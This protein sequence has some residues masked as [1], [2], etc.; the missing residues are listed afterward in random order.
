MDIRAFREKQNINSRPDPKGFS[1][2]AFLSGLGQKEIRF[3]NPFG[4]KQ[5]ERFFAEIGM[6]LSAGV[7]LQTILKLSI[8]GAKTGDRLFK[9]YETILDQ[10]KQGE[11]LAAAMRI[12]GQFN[13]FDCF[14]VL[15]GENTGNLTDVFNRL[16]RYYNK[17]VIQR[18]KVNSSLS[19]P[20]IVLL[21]TIGTIYFMLKFVVPMF[22]ETLVKFGGELPPLTLL[23]IKLSHND[24]NYLIIAA[25]S[26]LCLFLLYKRN[27]HNNR[28]RLLLS[29]LVLSIPYVGNLVYKTH[30]VQ[31]T[32]AMDLLLSSNVNV[33]ESI[34]LAENIVRFYPLQLAVTDIKHELLKGNYFYKS[35]E[36]QSFFPKPMV[37]L[38]R[39]GEEVNQLDRIFGQLSKQFENELEY[40]SGV[41]I[42]ILE[43]LMILVLAL[44]VAII[45]ISMYLPMFKIGSIIH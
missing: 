40:Q 2:I 42:S 11:N 13:N 19:Y 8:E 23:V 20:I 3:L 43:P 30:L 24:S 37:T 6:L 1:I 4:N 15:I 32:Q 18:R 34:N 9:I 28:L 7:D 16:S 31:F 14:S 21:T 5:K 17:R 41:L 29:N 36:K 27:K 38:V 39:I 10:V 44:L 33:M 22:S 12:T 25:S 26:C 45:L 35:M